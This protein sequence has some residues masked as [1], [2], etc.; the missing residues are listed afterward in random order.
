MLSYRE[1][2]LSTQ[3]PNMAFSGMSQVVYTLV[4]MSVRH[5]WT[6]LAS[7]SQMPLWMP[8]S[9]ITEIRSGPSRPNKA[10]WNQRGASQCSFLPITLVYL[11]VKRCRCQSCGFC[12]MWGRSIRA[13]RPL[14]SL[15][16]KPR[17]GRYPSLGFPIRTG[18]FCSSWEGGSGCRLL[19][20]G[21]WGTANR[22]QGTAIWSLAAGGA[23]VTGTGPAWG[24]YLG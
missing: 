21:V 3:G 15:A 14:K 2:W 22:A 24:T 18:L 8:E 16:L 9:S 12:G 4:K 20:G 5:C 6:A 13:S 11:H 1:V 23:R 10:T 7:P 19:R 17:S